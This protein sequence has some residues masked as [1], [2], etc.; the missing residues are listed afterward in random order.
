MCST[1]KIT[2]RVERLRGKGVL[3]P[4]HTVFREL[5]DTCRLYLTLRCKTQI[6]G[7]STPLPRGL[8]ACLPTYYLND[9]AR[10]RWRRLRAQI[11]LR[12]PDSG[13]R[14]VERKA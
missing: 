10:T 2:L 12:E 5:G 14:F 4:A 7:R 9:F 3:R 1:L 11:G 13:G 6:A 8:L